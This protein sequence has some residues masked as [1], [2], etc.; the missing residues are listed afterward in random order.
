MFDS[1]WYHTA[2]R[3]PNLPSGAIIAL[4]NM[5][6][7]AVGSHGARGGDEIRGEML[8]S[9]PASG[10]L[11][12]SAS[13]Q[14][15]LVGRPVHAAARVGVEHIHDDEVVAGLKR[16]GRQRVDAL[17]QHGELPTARPF[18]NVRSTSSICPNDKRRRLFRLRLGELDVRAI[19]DHAVVARASAERPSFPRA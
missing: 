1:P 6:M 4:Y 17:A 13:V 9:Q 19:P 11:V 2:P 18:T 12:P 3:S 16:A 15:A 14:Y 5:L 8:Y 10:I 7:P